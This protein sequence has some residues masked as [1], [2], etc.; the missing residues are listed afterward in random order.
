MLNCFITASAQGMIPIRPLM[1]STFDA[2]YAVQDARLK[3]WIKT[4][5]FTADPGA[6]CLV[7]DHDGQLAFVLVGVATADDFWV[8]G[9]LPSRLGIGQY[10]IDWVEPIWAEAE[11]RRAVVAWGL[12]SYSFT[13]YQKKNRKPEVGKAQL[14]IPA[15]AN[16]ELCQEMV[17]SLY[18]VRDLINTPA[19]D[20]GPEQLTEAASQL[21][22]QYGS[23]AKV[24]IGDELLAANYPA[25]YAVGRG[26][27]RA[28]RL[29]DFQWGENSAPLLTLV[30]KGICFDSGGLNLKSLDGMRIMKKDMAGAAHA[31]G[32]A[33]MIMSQ[34]LPVRLRVLIPIAENMV[35]GNSYRP[36]DIITTRAGISVE[37]ANTDAEGRLVLCDALAAAAT[38]SPDLLLDFATLTGAARVA[39]GPDIA[40]FFANQE[41]LAKGLTRAGEQSRDPVWRLPLHQPYERYLKSEIADICNATAGPYAGAITAALYLKQFVPNTIPWAHFDL[42]AWN[43]DKLPGRPCGGEANALRAVFTYLQERYIKS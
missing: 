42:S 15:A 16:P 5:R 17:A 10:H 21:A 38:E 24:L 1:K 33:R 6:I 8:F 4:T 9:D 20:M 14:F 7:P 31:L 23:T 35:A 22:K 39:V 2:W 36:G 25:I 34:R 13:R 18:W 27:P 11:W 26:S 40:A 19:E 28:P 30:G 43:F 12:G 37:I 41:D 32:L 29:V 3:Q